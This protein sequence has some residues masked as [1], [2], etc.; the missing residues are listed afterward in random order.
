ML[1]T[2]GVSR[3][4]AVAEPLNGQRKHVSDEL[5]FLLHVFPLR[6]AEKIK[7]PKEARG[8]HTSELILQIFYDSVT[9]ATNKVSA[10]VASI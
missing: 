4:V 5:Q 3:L 10:R 6:D 8:G 1:R 7:N 9:T 2:L